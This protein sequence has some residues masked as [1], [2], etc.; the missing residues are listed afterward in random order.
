MP[1]RVTEEDKN[2][3]R[4][5]ISKKTEELIKEVGFRGVTITGICQAVPVG[6]GTFYYYYPSKEVLLFEIFVENE[7]NLMQK[8]IESKKENLSQQENITRAIA[9]IYL[10]EESLVTKI[11]PEEIHELIS[12]LPQAYRDEKVQRG[13]HFF[14]KVITLLEIDPTRCNMGVVGELLD[15]INFI[16]AKKSITEGAKK[17]AIEIMIKSLA[18]Y[19]TQ[20]N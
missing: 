11:T 12:A 9:E 3:A 4:Q 13:T 8:I 20:G 16:A 10:G 1:K 7:K 2:I 17:E 15:S 14:E 19:M 5:L 18:S 6:K